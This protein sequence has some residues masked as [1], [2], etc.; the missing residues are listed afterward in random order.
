MYIRAS[1]NVILSMECNEGPVDELG[2]SREMTHG[3]L[4]SAPD[5]LLPR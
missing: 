2:C 1:K 5:F 3:H 4:T